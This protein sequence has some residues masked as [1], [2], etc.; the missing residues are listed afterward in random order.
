MGL[1]TDGPDDD[2]RMVAVAK[3]P[4]FQIAS[5]PFVK[6]KGSV[7]LGGFFEPTIEDFVH[8]EDAKLVAKVV[9]EVMMGIVGSADGVAAH[10]FEFAEF[11]FEEFGSPSASHGAAGEVF[12]DAAELGDLAVEVKAGVFVPLDG[13]DT[14]GDFVGVD[15]LAV[16]GEGQLGGVER[17]GVEVPELGVGNSE[18]GC[19]VLLWSGVGGGDHFAAG[20]LNLDAELEAGGV[21]DLGFDGDSRFGVVD[22]GG[23]DEGGVVK[24]EVFGMGRDQAHR[25][26]DA[27]GMIPTG[28]R[29]AG[30]IDVDFDGV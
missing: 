9:E 26:V 17:G 11:P 29:L 27:A 21:F 7:V 3:N 22:F 5:P 6:V 12:A 1:V 2:G 14:E 23:G 4:L 13:A 30:V 25:G 28:G 19:F 15:C 10:R 16:F 24:E 8:H 18:A 20:A